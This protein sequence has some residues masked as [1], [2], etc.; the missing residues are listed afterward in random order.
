MEETVTCQLCGFKG[1]RLTTHILH[2]H[3][4]PVALY[5]ERFGPILSEAE[6]SRQASRASTRNKTEEARAASKVGADKVN[7]RYAEDPA[8]RASVDQSKRDG[9]TP[10]ARA[11]YGP[12]SAACRHEE[13]KDPS[14]RARGVA[15][16][17][18]QMTRQ[19]VENRPRFLEIGLMGSRA[20][21][22]PESRAKQYDA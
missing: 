10:T 17:S 18:Q 9:W 6:S 22:S 7:K 16:S 11:A 20:A 8:F 4:M 21:C 15:A 12:V 1:K 13:W 3:K 14:R 2:K 19:W 5:K